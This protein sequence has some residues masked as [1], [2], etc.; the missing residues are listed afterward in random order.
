MLG[1]YKALGG[2]TLK[3]EDSLNLGGMLYCSQLPNSHSLGFQSFSG[4]SACMLRKAQTL[5]RT[6]SEPCKELCWTKGPWCNL[7]GTLLNLQEPCWKVAQILPEPCWSRA[8]TLLE[9]CWSPASWNLAGT[10]LESHWKLVNP[11]LNMVKPCWNLAGTLLLEPLAGTFC[12]EPMRVS[13]SFF[14]LH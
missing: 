1:C 2:S 7:A 9:P 8:R 4:G 6:S 5:A 14:Y 13:I 10:L 12:W 11:C 3:N